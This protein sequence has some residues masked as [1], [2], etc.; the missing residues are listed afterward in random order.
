[1][2]RFRAYLQLLRPPNLLTAMSDILAGFAV[3]VGWQYV[4]LPHA[5]FPAAPEIPAGLWG[6]LVWLLLA[7]VGLYGG[8]V[9]LN[10]YYDAGL[11]SKERPERP[12]PSG[13]V[14]KHH[15]AILGYGLLLSAVAVS[16]KVNVVSGAIAT[17]IVV[18]VLLYNLVSKNHALLGPLNM[19]LCRG[20][21]LMLGVSIIPAQVFPLLFVS[22]ISVVYIA[23]ITLISTG[24]VHGSTKRSFNLG[25]LMYILVGIM[26]LALGFL[27]QYQWLYGLPFL[28]LL[29]FLIIPSI[30]KAR[31]M[32]EPQLIGQ[33]VKVSVLALISLNAAIAAGFTG[34]FF[35]LLLLLLLP[36]S[37]ML[38]RIFAVT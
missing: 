26:V 10:D 18:L 33:A 5:F 14:P 38:A 8:G 4:S 20:C 35:G 36:L 30:L 24:E 34:W 31:N 11:D 37:K 27:D 22:V 19:G 32:N 2:I 28:L 25:L 29:Y 23:A 9:V 15:A 1:M 17:L 7:T 16:F 6:N 13:K 3:T 12:I 21:N